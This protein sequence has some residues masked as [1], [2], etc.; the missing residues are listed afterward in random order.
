MFNTDK[1]RIKTVKRQTLAII[2]ILI[3]GGTSS[4]YATTILDSTSV[5]QNLTVLGTCTGCGGGEGSFT[6]YSLI[7]NATVAGGDNDPGTM[8]V[9]ADNGT[10]FAAE[11]GHYIF[12][13]SKTGAVTGKSN[14]FANPLTLADILSVSKSNSGE[15]MT[16]YDSSNKTVTIFKNNSFLQHIPVDTINVYGDVGLAVAIS[17]NGKYIG[18]FGLDQS[19]AFDRIQIWEG[20]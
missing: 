12:S 7:T 20:S 15:Y 18:I 6:T 1:F 11:K 16:M 10:S 2:L 19:G 4:V 3:A 17:G 8:I 13:L 5:F 14:N 9:V